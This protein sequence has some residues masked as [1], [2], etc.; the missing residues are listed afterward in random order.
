MVV[1]LAGCRIHG[2]KNVTDLAKETHFCQFLTV[3][4]MTIYNNTL[5]EIDKDQVYEPGVYSPPKEEL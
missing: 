3:K 2:S 4:W 5:W 1:K